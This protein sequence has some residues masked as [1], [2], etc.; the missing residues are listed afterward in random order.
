MRS[1][2]PTF[3]KK[4][5][6]CFWVKSHTAGKHR[7]GRYLNALSETGRTS[8]KKVPMGSG[9]NQRDRATCRFIQLQIYCKP[10]K[11]IGAQGFCEN[12][13]PGRRF[14]CPASGVFFRDQIRRDLG[15]VHLS[16]TPNGIFFREVRPASEMGCKHRQNRLLPA[17][18]DLTPKARK[19]FSNSERL[20]PCASLASVCVCVCVCSVF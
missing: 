14:F 8:R 4:R 10:G 6:S 19:T 9:L 17:V 13:S 5:F 1:L 18:C 2:T 3:R 15:L 16:Q 12:Q 20:F 11:K 7:L